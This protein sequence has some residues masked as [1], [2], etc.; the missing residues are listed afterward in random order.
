MQEISH[1]LRQAVLNKIA[2]LVVAGITIPIN[3]SFLNPHTKPAII[4]GGKAYVLIGPQ[5]EA[6]TTNN[7]CASRQAV[8]LQIDIV[9]KFPMGSG[10]KITS[11]LISNQIQSAMI[12][13][14]TI[15][16][17]QVLSITKEFSNSLIEQG[18]SEVA[19]R[20]LINYRFDIFQV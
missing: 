13:P 9:T 19:Y 8:S 2:P 4:A 14:F 6:E 20:K 17:F 18:V 10:G 3:D 11:E 1:L 15:S 12:L 7:R 16:G 5:N